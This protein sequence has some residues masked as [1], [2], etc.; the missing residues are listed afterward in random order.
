MEGRYS[1][2]AVFFW[3]MRRQTVL[4]M[5][6]FVVLFSIGAAAISTSALSQELLRYYRNKQLLKEAEAFLGRLE[7]LNADYDALLERL[8]NEPDILKHIA[9]ATLG[10]EPSDTDTIYPKATAEQLAVAK[11]ILTEDLS[12]QSIEPQV[13]DWVLR[14]SEPA[15]RVVLFVAGALLI[16]I[17]FVWFGSAGQ[18]ELEKLQL[19]K[20]QKL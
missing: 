18:K 8:R 3:A 1:A 5:L 17:S 11:R 2:A 12:R 10:T 16:I 19:L 9:P 4:R 20:R 14:C 7:S 6:L 15:R 13:P